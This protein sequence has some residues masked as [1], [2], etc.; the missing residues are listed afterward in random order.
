MKNFLNYLKLRDK[1]LLMY[2][3]SVFIPIVLTNVVFYN[4]TTSNIRN[5]KI[6][7]A[8]MALNNLKN[9]L[10]VT[11][12]Q[13]VGLS[14]SLY[15]DSIFNKT[16]T[17]KFTSQKDYV[18]TF[19][20]YLR[21]ALADENM[22]GVRWYQ[23]YTDNPTILASGYMDRLT[24]E[25]RKSGWYT[26][27]LASSASYPTF[28]YTDQKFSLI[29]RLNNYNTGGFEQLV[30]IDLNIEQIHQIF[31]GSGFDGQVYLVDPQGRVQFGNV[32]AN[33]TKDIYFHEISF[34]GSSRIFDEAY[35]DIN[36]LK[37]WTLKGVMDE[38]SVLKEVRKSRSF[39]IW[40]ACINFVLPTIIIAVMSRS[41]HVRLVR[42]LRHMKKVKA[43]NFETIPPE[44]ARDEIGQLTAEFN[45][46]TETI[47]SLINEVYVADI[48]KKNLELK[49]QQAQLHAL[50][51]Q[52][53]PHFLF[54]S[55]ESVRMR[56]IIKGEKETAKIIQ[57][58]AKMF[59]KSLSW[60]HNDVTVR[61]EL[62]LIESFLTIQQ[63]RFGDKLEYSIV[64]EPAALGLRIPKMVLLPFVENASIHGIESSPD[65]GSIVI[66]VT[67]QADRLIFR[68]Q[69]NGI[70][71]DSDKLEELHRYLQDG[72]D[73]GEHVGMKNAYCRLKLCYREGFAFSMN[74][75]YREGTSI[76]I[77][78]P[79]MEEKPG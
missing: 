27:S 38:E 64:A 16:I 24:G 71:M 7:D 75:R 62:E 32:T 13:G 6:R 20:S 42:I 69:D 65:K 49:Q 79:V 48:Q 66:S 58:M 45:R 18:D 77:S 60:S 29:Q 51:S 72:D 19:N 36:Y 44:D 21:G 30:K 11:I 39:V 73:I 78:L 3:L 41:I 35:S 50:H 28:I 76:E 57:H 8:D 43:Q 53:N 52:I 70:G 74:A 9:D 1:L 25:I 34:P 59:R 37:G 22:Q 31:E 61:E 67:L 54:N 5:Q 14:Y 46:M 23:V 12:D 56:S 68:F 15:T 10:R 26:R 4:V 33:L 55:L 2:M 63:Y 40:L 17:R 47:N